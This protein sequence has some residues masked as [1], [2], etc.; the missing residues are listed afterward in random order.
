MSTV[1]EM[2]FKNICLRVE[3]EQAHVI[4][5]GATAVNKEWCI[6]TVVKYFCLN[7]KCSNLTRKRVRQFS[8]FKIPVQSSIN[9][10]ELNEEESA[11]E[12][13]SCYGYK[14]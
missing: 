8:N 11:E 6:E 7:K 10:A 13:C 5:T 9:T 1:N 4:N 2:E 12:C 3:Y 14:W